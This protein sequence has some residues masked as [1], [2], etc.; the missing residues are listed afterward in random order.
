M[1]NIGYFDS[2]AVEPGG[3][4]EALPPGEYIASIVESMVKDNKKGTGKFLQVTWEILSA[5]GKGRR[6]WQYINFLNA[7]AK[8]QQIGQAELSA[9]CRAAGKPNISD[10]SQL[11]N[12]P[13]TVKL[14]VDEYNGEKKNVIKSVQWK[15]S[16][17][18]AGPQEPA[19]D[20]DDQPPF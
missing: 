18:A 5:Q 19:A 10:S 20:D 1:G 15:K 4:Y 6:V 11:H 2:A 9:I 13:M 17:V 14:G 8:A 16:A 7:S 12:I 3:S